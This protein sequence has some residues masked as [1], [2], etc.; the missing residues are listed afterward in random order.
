MINFD[1][2]IVCVAFCSKGI[3][4][5]LEA[6]LDLLGLEII[7]QT[8]GAVRFKGT[9]RTVYAACL[10]SRLAN[11]ILLELKVFKVETASQIYD[12]C[13]EINWEEHF[14]VDQTISV[15][16]SGTSSFIKNSLYA[17]QLVKDAVVDRFRRLTGLR[18]SVDPVQSD[19][20]IYGKLKRGRLGVM[21]DLSGK[22]LHRRGYRKFNVNAPLKENLAAAL[23]LRSNWSGI[24]ANGGGLIDPMCGCG[25]LIIEA[26]MIAADIAPGLM[27]QGFAFT[28][29]S[30]HD[31]KIWEEVVSDAEQRRKIGLLGLRQEILGYDSDPRA[32]GFAKKNIQEIGLQKK[33]NVEIKPVSHLQKPKSET[34]LVITNPPYG[35]RIGE[36]SSLKQVYQQFGQ[37]LQLHF[38][39]WRAAVLSGNSV[40][41][42]ELDLTP[43]RQYQ[44]SNGSIP[45]KLFLFDDIHS[46]S[47]AI[48]YRIAARRSP[49]EMT[50]GSSMVVNR[51][52]KNQ[53][54]LSPW[55]K[56]N[57]ITCYRLYDADLPEYSAAIDIYGQFIHVQEYYAPHT[58]ERSIAKKRFQELRDAVASF[59]PESMEKT[60][61]KVRSRQRGKDQYTRVGNEHGKPLIVSEGPARFEINLGNYVD[62]GIF[63]DHRKMRRIIGAEASGKRFLNLFCY[64]ASAT[65]MAALNGALSSLSCDMSSTY[66]E[67]ARRNF[68]LNKLAIDR[69]QLLKVD[70][71]EWLKNKTESL[72]YFDIILLDPPTFSNS[73][74]MSV[75]FD[76]QR[77]HEA[78]IRAAAKRLAP[79][80]TL[81]FSNNFRKFKMSPNLTDRFLVENMTSETLDLDFR[82]NPRIHNAWRIKHK[83]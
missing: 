65:V 81:Y 39:K 4:P 15:D 36:A 54:R 45:C 71:V 11:R 58:I 47:A 74:K 68:Q 41:A 50:A 10:W 46:K 55:L 44:F 73:K 56:K 18:P 79:C 59:A 35:E 19:I 78:I 48:K 3:E 76:I 38:G 24:A 29:W 5:L 72:E 62:S 83:I 20:S 8:I 25:T 22:S 63:L 21:L 57:N 49:K 75:S 69:H 82:R 60:F 26:A 9:L 42:R 12:G 37:R 40:L 61:Y 52:V 14:N 43:T 77:D 23:L 17:S 31:T 70:C 28:A 6:E 34:G 51:L 64:T 13:G 27:R 53:R 66:I 32:V 30:A 67:W 7:K 1:K 2:K 80:G 33:I 16:F